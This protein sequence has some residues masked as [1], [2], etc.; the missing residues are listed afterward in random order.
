MNNNYK[1][2]L[3]ATIQKSHNRID[4][5][6]DEV[7]ATSDDPIE[8]NKITLTTTKAHKRL[9]AAANIIFNAISEE[10]KEIDELFE[11]NHAKKISEN[12][13]EIIDHHS[14]IVQHEGKNGSPTFIERIDIFDYEDD[15]DFSFSAIESKTFSLSED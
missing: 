10:E 2:N 14:R 1:K 11:I 3:K 8:R 5:A 4:A 13:V 9:D 7:L 15:E 6:M 12:S